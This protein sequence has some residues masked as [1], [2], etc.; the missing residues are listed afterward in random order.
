MCMESSAGS[1]FHRERS[2]PRIRESQRD[3]ASKPRVGAQRLPWEED[4]PNAQP[5]RGCGTTATP[6]AATP[7]GLRPTSCRFPRVA[8]RLAGQPWALRRNPFGIRARAQTNLW[9][10]ES[11][12]PRVLRSTPVNAQEVRGHFLRAA[13]AQKSGLPWLLSA[14]NSPIEVMREIS[15]PKVDE[16]RSE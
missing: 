13:E 12:G 10:N 14:W 8:S 6:S 4:R 3:S 16:N 7:L 9:G 11:F 2:R 15:T 5:Q 1:I